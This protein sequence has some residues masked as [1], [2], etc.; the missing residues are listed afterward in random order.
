MGALL[1]RPTFIRRNLVQTVMDAMSLL[2]IMLLI[3]YTLRW[4][5]NGKDR[6]ACLLYTDASGI[7]DSGQPSG[8]GA[9]SL[10]LHHSL[11]DDLLRISHRSPEVWRARSLAYCVAL[12]QCGLSFR[13]GQRVTVLYQAPRY[14]FN[15]TTV[16]MTFTATV[17]NIEQPGSSAK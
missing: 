6:V 13:V 7:E 1:I 3:V 11:A 8:G 2:G 10:A 15:F 14:V 4:M 5:V 16:Y 9:S 12:L 17:L